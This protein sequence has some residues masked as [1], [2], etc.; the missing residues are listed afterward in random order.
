M[1]EELRACVAAGGRVTLADDGDRVNPVSLAGYETLLRSLPSE[2]VV[3]VAP[4]DDERPEHALLYLPSF[5][6]A[7]QWRFWLEDV[8]AVAYTRAL[9]E[10]HRRGLP[11]ELDNEMLELQDVFFLFWKVSPRKRY[12]LEK[13]YARMRQLELL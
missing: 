4:A 6:L 8:D 2:A 12:Y 1:A 3:T 11:P 5:S 7:D 9:D 10:I 13:L